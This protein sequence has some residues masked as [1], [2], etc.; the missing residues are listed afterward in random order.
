M[1]NELHLVIDDKIKFKYDRTKPLA[2]LQRRFLEKMD[3]D[4]DHGITVDGQKISAPD[5]MQRV[6]YVANHIVNSFLNNKQQAFVAGCAYLAKT[7]PDL[8]QITLE[9]HHSHQSISL[10]F[11][12]ATTKKLT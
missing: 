5:R 7:A 9:S 10:L 1:N 3:F 12:N 8:Q 6:Q 4:M 11:D 2:G